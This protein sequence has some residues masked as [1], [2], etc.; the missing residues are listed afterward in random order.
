MTETWNPTTPDMTSEETVRKHLTRHLNEL[1][2]EIAEIEAVMGKLEDLRAQLD[3]AG[4]ALAAFN[5]SHPAVPVELFGCGWCERTF[6]TKGGKARHERHA[7][8]PIER[9]LLGDES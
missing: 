8:P 9:T 6:T 2:G 1:T 7:H 3:R 4:R 5:D